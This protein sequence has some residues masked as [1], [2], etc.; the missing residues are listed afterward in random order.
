VVQRWLDEGRRVLVNR[1]PM[2]LKDWNH[3][4]Q[5]SRKRGVPVDIDW[6]LGV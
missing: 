1:P 2:Y 6:G 4:L 5:W 3:L